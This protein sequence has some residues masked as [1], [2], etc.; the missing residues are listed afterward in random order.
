MFEKFEKVENASLANFSTMKTGGNARWVIFPKNQKE[1]KEIFEICRRNNIKTFLLGNGSNVLFDDKGFCGA[2]ISLKHFNKIQI[3]DI[4]NGE[5]VFVRVGGGV[6]LFALGSRLAQMGVGGLEWCFGIPATLGGFVAC[7]GGCFGFEIGQ[8]VESVRVLDEFGSVKTL[9]KNA[10]KFSY[11]NSNLRKFAI[12]SI[13][14]RLFYQKK[15]QILK[16]MNFF[17]QK[18]RTLQPCELP[19]LG[20]V[21]KKNDLKNINKSNIQNFVQLNFEQQ[22]NIKNAELKNTQLKKIK[23][24]NTEIQNA[25]SQIELDG[26]FLSPAKIIDQLG[27]KGFCVGGA[28]ISTKHAGFIVN[29]GSATSADVLEVV[30]FLENTFLQ[31]GIVLEREIQF[32]PYD[33]EKV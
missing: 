15:E 6:N 4:Q 24:K 16:N 10:L 27:L 14:L 31:V 25:K 5:N 11:R 1:L 12:L 32:L 23:I 2:V 28:Q 8:F 30:R 33:G 19:S 20:S 13:K 7:N 29:T 21:F 9:R 22:K 26:Q 3:C 18:K 17:L